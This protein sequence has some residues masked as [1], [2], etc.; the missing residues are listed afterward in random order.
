MQTTHWSSIQRNK[1]KPHIAI[2]RSNQYSIVLKEDVDEQAP[3]NVIVY[4]VR[5]T[6]QYLA[7]AEFYEVY[8]I[9]VHFNF[10]FNC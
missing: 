2:E 8:N 1:L 10:N 4:T 9:D 5:T 3:T 7:V 6:H